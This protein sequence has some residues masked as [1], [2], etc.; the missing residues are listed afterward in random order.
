MSFDIQL[1]K[2]YHMYSA[3]DAFIKNNCHIKVVV[4]T[5]QARSNYTKVGGGRGRPAHLAVHEGR[6][7][8]KN[9]PSPSCRVTF[10]ENKIRLHLTGSFYHYTQR[11]VFFLYSLSVRYIVIV[12]VIS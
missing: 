8:P 10:N 6:C 3:Y 1:Y 9:S 12:W 2:F 7:M 5:L 11:S 4:F